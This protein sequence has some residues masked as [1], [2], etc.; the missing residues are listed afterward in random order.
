M[1]N[2][3]RSGQDRRISPA[4]GEFAIMDAQRMRGE[5]TA[6]LEAGVHLAEKLKHAKARIADL[7]KDM[8]DAIDTETGNWEGVDDEPGWLQRFRDQLA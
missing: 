1:S 8:Q 4:I 5:T 2:D 3:K 6:A 7:R